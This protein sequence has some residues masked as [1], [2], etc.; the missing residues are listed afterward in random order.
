MDK[1]QGH[2]FGKYIKS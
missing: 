1:I 2:K